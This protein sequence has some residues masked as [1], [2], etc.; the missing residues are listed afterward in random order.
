MSGRQ[1]DAFVVPVAQLVNVLAGAVAGE[2][3]DTLDADTRTVVDWLDSLFAGELNCATVRVSHA[4]KQRIQF[5]LDALRTDEMVERG[6]HLYVTQEEDG[7]D[8]AP[9]YVCDQCG[10]P[11]VYD[12]DGCVS[13]P[14]HGSEFLPP[15]MERAMQ[16]ALDAA[17]VPDLDALPVVCPSCAAARAVSLG[18][19][20]ARHYF[21]CKECGTEFWLQEFDDRTQEED[22]AE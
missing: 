22:G 10:A 21:S 18:R 12:S 6:Q 1:K 2:N 19:R 7:A 9:E 20:G 5:M 14:V 15:A 8:M 11:L 13:C 17:G 4:T 3:Y 16:R